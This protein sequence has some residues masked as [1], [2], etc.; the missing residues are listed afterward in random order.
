MM[1]VSKNTLTIIICVA[2]GI[3]IG[4]SV[5]RPTPFVSDP[6]FEK[7]AFI[8]AP[9]SEA[10]KVLQ[11]QFIGTLDDR[12]LSYGAVEGMV[13]AA[14]DPY[15]GFSDPEETKQFKDT[16][17]GSFSGIGAEMGIDGGLIVVIAPLV[18][19]PAE[20]AG[21]Q[22]GDIIVAIDGKE[23]TEDTSLD[24]AVRMIRGQ[25]GTQVKITVIHSDAREKADITITRDDIEVQS[26]K[27]ETKD[28]I[29]HISISSFNGDTSVKFA[30]AARDAKKAGVNGII[31]DV[32]RNPG[33]YLDAAVDIASEFLEPN[34]TV[35]IEK[36]KTESTH[37]AKRTGSLRGIPTVVL[38]NE[39]SASAS[40]ILA[41]ALE[42][43]LGTAIIGVKS[44]GKGSVQ[45]VV[46]LS[47]GSSLRVTIAKWF[48][49]KGTSIAD[50]GIHP[51]I[52]VKDNDDT[53][54]DEQLQRAM[55]ELKKS[56]K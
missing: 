32:R 53:P 38:I 3:A 19:S 30:K 8:F 56:I 7:D 16:L 29:A 54:E 27:S 34:A 39:S 14:G 47:D 9:F 36:G 4:M 48:T 46:D 33:G 10:K 40:E 51:T 41:G 1:L 25:K 15:T 28:G 2:I 31:L 13:R 35:V 17:K 18:G 23:L 12:Q 52:E 55:E 37:R 21:I 20:K 45:D 50:E 5:A 42:D 6:I 44:F 49:P 22:A 43:N 26:V 24:D 11:D